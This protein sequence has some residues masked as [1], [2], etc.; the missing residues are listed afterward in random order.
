MPK[1][2]LRMPR[3][4]KTDANW[5]SIFAPV[6]RDDEARPRHARFAF[7]CIARRLASSVISCIAI[8]RE[9]PPS[10]RYNTV[11]HR[12]EQSGKPARQRLHMTLHGAKR[13]PSC[14]PSV[15]T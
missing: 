8:A 5:L 12:I 6:E 7:S 15:P 2:A 13:E 3:S 11:K 1:S 4:A 14:P 10:L 9:V